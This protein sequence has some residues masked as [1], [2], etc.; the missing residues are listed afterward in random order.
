MY[1]YDFE[2]MLFIKIVLSFFFIQNQI[3]QSAL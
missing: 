3:E 1:K 2:K